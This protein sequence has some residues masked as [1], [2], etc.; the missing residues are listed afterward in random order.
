[1]YRQETPQFYRQLSMHIPGDSIDAELLGLD[2]FF[3]SYWI[4]GR[5]RRGLASG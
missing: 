4:D 2:A 3:Q 1:M 5:L